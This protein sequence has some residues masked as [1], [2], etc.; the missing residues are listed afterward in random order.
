VGLA[1]TC[2]AYEARLEL[3]PAN[4]R[5]VVRRNWLLVGDADGLDSVSHARTRCPLALGLGDYQ[6]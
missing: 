6:T 1:P 4:P 3:S 5:Y 2:M